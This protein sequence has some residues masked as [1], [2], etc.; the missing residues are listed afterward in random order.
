MKKG[1]GTILNLESERMLRKYHYFVEGM[2]LCGKYILE[3][4]DGFLEDTHHYSDKNCK[5]CVIKR[6]KLQK[7]SENERD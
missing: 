4:G 3:G 5:I 6:F 2:S 7:E 1:W